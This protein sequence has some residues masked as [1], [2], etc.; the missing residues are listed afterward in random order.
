[1][2]IPNLGQ[3]QAHLQTAIAVEWSTIPPY[4]CARWSLLDGHNAAAAACLD[5]VVM[6]E[7]L[8]LT[9]ASNLLNAIGGE[10]QLIPP[11]ASPPSYPT[12]LPHSD[13]AFTVN[14]LPFSRK[15]LQTFRS[16]ERPAAV[17]GPP[18][19]D[20]FHTLAQFYEAVGEALDR[21][22]DHEDIF[23]G[24]PARQVESG[25]YYGGGGEAFAV[26]DLPSAEKALE[27]IVFEGEGIGDSIWDGDQEL[28][29]ED[30]ELAHYFR[31]DELYQG[32]RYTDGDS[33]STGPTGPPVLV[34][35][36]AVLPMR[37]NPQTTRYPRGSELRAMSE[38]CDATYSL[39]LTQLQAAFNGAPDG[40]VESVQ[41]MLTL[42][43]EAIAL[44]RV[45]VADG[46]TA[47]PAFAWHPSVSA[48]R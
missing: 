26:H 21:L 47:G 36:E 23:T 8:H 2:T 24:P 34:D 15:A 32:R 14:L 28:L 33:P 40:L 46:Q 35:Y 39:L 41:T 13:N 11:A 22:A 48:C 43:L 20:R 4:L 31:F 1:M 30:R 27:V 12:Y 9:L 7:M 44:M 19:P 17:G 3:L 18:E 5:D 29:G 42:R 10:P 38:A 16:I 45:P 6:E 37:P 25:Y